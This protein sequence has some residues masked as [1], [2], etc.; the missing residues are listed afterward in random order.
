MELTC[1]SKQLTAIILLACENKPNFYPQEKVMG[2]F[3]LEL[4]KQQMKITP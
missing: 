2:W 3:V 1:S 4:S